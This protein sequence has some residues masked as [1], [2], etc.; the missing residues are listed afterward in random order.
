MIRPRK[1]ILIIWG[2]NVRKD[3][4]SRGMPRNVKY[5]DI[6]HV[7]STLHCLKIVCNTLRIRNLKERWPWKKLENMDAYPNPSNYPVPN[8]SS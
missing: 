3:L 4:P 7:S 8:P 6:C 2:A 5:R 1:V